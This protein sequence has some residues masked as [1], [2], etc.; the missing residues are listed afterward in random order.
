MIPWPTSHGWE[1]DQQ[2]LAH[3]FMQIRGESSRDG[4]R[5]Q[6]PLLAVK[7]VSTGRSEHCVG[8]FNT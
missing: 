4:E 2:A 7:S 5:K 6:V 3:G 8:H 1:A